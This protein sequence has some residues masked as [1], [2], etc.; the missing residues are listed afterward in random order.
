[1][2]YNIEL[3]HEPIQH[4]IAPGTLILPIHMF[5]GFPGICGV[6]Q[7]DAS[8]NRGLQDLSFPLSQWKITVGFSSEGGREERREVSFR[9]IEPTLHILH[10]QPD[11][12]LFF[13]GH[14][15]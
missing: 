5:K 9:T 2:I 1:V 3:L 15:K 4:E 6:G 8:N 12:K 10:L 7:V 11:P 13:E 14:H